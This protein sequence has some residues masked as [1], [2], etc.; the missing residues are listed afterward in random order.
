V[1]APPSEDR[2]EEPAV[3]PRPWR[4]PERFSIAWRFGIDEL[5]QRGEIPE[6]V[7]RDLIAAFEDHAALSEARATI[8]RVRAEML[9]VYG[10]IPTVF[11]RALAPPREGGK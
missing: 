6:V 11:Q 5:Y 9:R 1:T 8:E 3:T 10:E 2:C 4:R 7:W